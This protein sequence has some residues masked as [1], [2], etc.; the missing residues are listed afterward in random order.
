MSTD[1]PRRP[2]GATRRRKVIGRGA[3]SGSG[4][5]AGRGTKG[6]NA[7]SGGGVRP[8][9]EGGQMPLFR[10][11]ARRGFSNVRFRTATVA[12]GLDALEAA[13]AD[14]DAVDEDALVGK[15][16]LPDAATRVKILANGALTRKLEVRLA[17]VSAAARAAIEAAG[18][19]VLTSE[20][21]ERK[22]SAAVAGTAPDGTPA[23]ASLSDEGEAPSS[24]AAA[25]ADAADAPAEEPDGQ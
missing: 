15:G 23:P 21:A 9:F 25:A 11:V 14:G 3:G 20:K 8:G 24:G 7:R 5:T 22:P 13:F 1:G 10:R 19:S 2:R 18:G 16:L 17:K 4:A 12:L 6:Q